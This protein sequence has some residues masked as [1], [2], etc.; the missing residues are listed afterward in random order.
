[1]FTETHINYPDLECSYFQRKGISENA[2]FQMDQLFQVLRD[3]CAHL[4]ELVTKK[5][6]FL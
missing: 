5:F 3:E 1:M 2:I 4:D 6:F